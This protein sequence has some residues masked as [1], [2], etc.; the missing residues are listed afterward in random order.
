MKTEALKQALDRYA[1]DAACGEARRDDE[2]SR[3]EERIFSVR[4][5]HT[6][7]RDGESMRVFPLSNWTEHD[8]WTTSQQRKSTSCRS[9][10]PRCGSVVRRGAVWIAVDD[11]RLPLKHGELRECE[12]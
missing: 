12:E 6:P 8:V 3:A 7:L 1:F 4:S 2:R 11:E 5:A 10:S 9:I